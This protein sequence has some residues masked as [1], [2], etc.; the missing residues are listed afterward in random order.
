MV[1][2]KDL[3]RICYDKF[4]RIMRYEKT[5]NDCVG[6]SSEKIC[7]PNRPPTS[8]EVEISKRSGDPPHGDDIGDQYGG[9]DDPTLD[10]EEAL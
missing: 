5:R 10:V 7:W 2:G 9:R 6:C 1:D 8:E 4:R 3:K